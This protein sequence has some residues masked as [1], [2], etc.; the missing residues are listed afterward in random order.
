MKKKKTKKSKLPEMV[1][2]KDVYAIYIKLRRGRIDG[3]KSV[4]MKGNTVNLDYDKN[5]K[6]L[7]I[8]VV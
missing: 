8:E 3:T 6:L 5:G 1:V 2:D 7:G 4:K